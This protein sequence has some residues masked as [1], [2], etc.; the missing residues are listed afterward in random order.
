MKVIAT[1]ANRHH[2][3]SKETAESITLIEGLGVQGDAHCGVT[4]QHRS[5]V[6][7]DPFAPNLRQVHLLQSELFDELLTA[8]FE[9]PPGAMG[10]NIST[11]GIDLLALPTGAELRLG[12]SAVVQ[13]TGLRNPCLQI[14]KYKR[15]LMAA[16]LG[17][18]ADGQL[19]RKAGVMAVVLQG[20]V[21]AAG[22]RVK[23]ILPKG[24]HQVLQPV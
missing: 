18:T 22:D 2:T 8:G 14:D 9:V 5:R 15:G 6:A 3:F 21:V 7:K 13:V 11:Q 1:H 10:E 12:P 17:K 20:G 16:V 24:P 23:V 19:V 4:V